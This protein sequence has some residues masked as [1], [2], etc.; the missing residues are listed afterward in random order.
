MTHDPPYIDVAVARFTSAEAA[1]GVLESAEEL[2]QRHGG[3]PVGRESITPPHVPGV[4]QVR[5]FHSD[6]PPLATVDSLNLLGTEIVFVQGS[7]L[8]VVAV[9]VEASDPAVS[10]EQTD[11]I[12]SGLAEQQSECLHSTDPCGPVRVPEGLTEPATP[13]AYGGGSSPVR[14]AV[15]TNGVVRRED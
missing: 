15:V 13:V 5:A 3:A 9:Q 1:L 8:V 14:G 7:W 12:A 6:R 4:D 10:P 2:P 11:A